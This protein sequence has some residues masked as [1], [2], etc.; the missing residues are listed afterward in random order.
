MTSLII[1][2]HF[3]EGR[4]HGLDANGQAEWPPSPARLFQALVAGAAKGASITSED[5]DAFLWFEQLEP[6]LIA[7]PVARKGQEYRNYVPNNDLDAVQG[8][9]GRIAEIRSKKYFHPLLFNK[10]IPLHYVW[11][12]PGNDVSVSRI[13]TI[14][15]HLFQL[16]RGV[17][18]GWATFEMIARKAVNERLLTYPGSIYRPVRQGNAF[19]LP[20]PQQ[21]SFESLVERHAQSLAR[22]KPD[23][24]P[25]QTHNKPVRT[26]ATGMTLTNPPKPRFRNIPYDCPATI[27]QFELRDVTTQ[28]NFAP[29]PHTDVLN[30]VVLV[31]NSAAERLKIAMPDKEKL[32]LRV[33]GQ[34]REAVEAD[35]AIRLRIIPLPSIGHSYADHGIRR[36][37]V[38]I[39][40]NCPLEK[41]DVAWAFSGVG[42]VDRETGGT[43]WSLV[44]AADDVMRVHYGIENDLRQPYWTWRTVTPMALPIVRARGRCNGQ[45]RIEIE[46]GAIMAVSQAL[47]H[48]SLPGKFSSIRIQ[49]EPF[50]AK[51]AR[52]ESFASP[53]RFSANRLWHVELTYD[54]PITGPVQAGDGRYLGL[55]L[56]HPVKTTGDA[57]VYDI[58]HGLST[59]AGC[60]QVARA[61]RRAVMSLVQKRMESNN[62]KNLPLFFS[63]HEADES[64]A[65]REGKAHLAFVFDAARKRLII[66]PP[67]L[68]ERRK[69]DND[70]RNYLKELAAALTGL[71]ELRAG[72]AGLL[73]LERAIINLDADPLFFPATVWTTQTEYSPTRYAKRTSSEQTLI[74]DV[75]LEIRRRGLPKP[76]H[77]VVTGVTKG[78][79]GGLGGHLKLIFSVAVQGPI[80]LGKTCHFGGGL[81]SGV[82]RE[83]I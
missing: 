19:R 27:L 5:R 38:E 17:D 59:Q 66:L 32:I 47:R 81:F 79:K 10:D 29:W 83:S 56:F 8:D 11:S 15:S 71:H 75:E 43:A 30:F 20:V 70:E 37:L 26:K 21:G 73:K 53:P 51:N 55:G 16:G 72:S 49:R 31:R 18:M 46:N 52:A 28:A 60:L 36:I 3:H 65:R 50:E 39:P 68:L 9:I 24:A 77:I 54:Q 58:Y 78:P 45:E 2:I 6:P 41:D 42:A 82:K 12:F 23:I 64:P 80:L 74:A 44:T 62:K 33:F 61:L 1:T 34:C 13:C 67:H 69:P 7:V 25:M 76:E 14:V 57:H 48:A 4:F 63:G 40:P 22:F 35:K